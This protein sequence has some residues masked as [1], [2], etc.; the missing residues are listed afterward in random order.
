MEALPAPTAWPVS[1]RPR[2]GQME[3]AAS[4]NTQASSGLVTAGP[5]PPG[6]PGRVPKFAVHKDPEENVQ[7]VMEWACVD[8][9][10]GRGWQTLEA[11]VRKGQLESGAWWESELCADSGGRNDIFQTVSDLPSS[12][13]K[14]AFERK[15]VYGYLRVSVNTPMLQPFHPPG[16]PCP[17]CLKASSPGLHLTT[18]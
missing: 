10:E 15:S 17:P 8:G 14:D 3:K 13:E 7:L 11:L 12:W 4:C 5:V 18:S 9:K 2:Q 6:S 1:Q 16:T